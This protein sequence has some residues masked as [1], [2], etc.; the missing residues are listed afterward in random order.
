MIED[1][2]RW[3]HEAASGIPTM[4]MTGSAA[5]PEPMPISAERVSASPVPLL[6]IA[7]H[8]ACRKAASRTATRTSDAME[9]LDDGKAD[10]TRFGAWHAVAAD[11]TQFARS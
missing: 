6:A 4:A 10:S 7:F 1:A 2:S 8:V 9:C 3:G 5:R 11:E